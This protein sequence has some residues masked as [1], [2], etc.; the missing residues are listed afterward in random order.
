MWGATAALECR[1]QSGML[2]EIWLARANL[3]CQA[4]S[5]VPNAVGAAEGPWSTAPLLLAESYLK[6]VSGLR[7]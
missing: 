7:C 3:G 4:E 6:R 2:D 5:E 1:G